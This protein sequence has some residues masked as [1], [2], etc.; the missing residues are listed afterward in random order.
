MNIH[1][2]YFGSITKNITLSKSQAYKITHPLREQYRSNW[3]QKDPKLHQK[4][5]FS[6]SNTFFFIKFYDLTRHF[7]KLFEQKF[8]DFFWKWCFESILKHTFMNHTERIRIFFH[9]T[10][11]NNAL[12]LE[13]IIILNNKIKA[14]YYKQNYHMGSLLKSPNWIVKCILSLCKFMMN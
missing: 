6:I 5:P 10:E 9:K 3:I 13:Q 7:V 4:Y 12:E 14:L 11:Q 8:W 1:P 2:N